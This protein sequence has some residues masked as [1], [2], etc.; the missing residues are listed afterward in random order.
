MQTMEAR[1]IISVIPAK[2]DIGALKETEMKKI[3]VAAYCRVSTG[4]E[5]QETSFEAQVGYYTQLINT[6]PG[7]KMAGIYA[8]DGISGTR[9][10]KRTDLQRMIQDWTDVNKVDRKKCERIKNLS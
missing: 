7:W 1:K 5:E 8:D 10:E 3:R 2:K 4:L 9:I 6:T